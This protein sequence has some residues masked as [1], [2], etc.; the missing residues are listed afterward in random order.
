MR[1]V[2]LV[3]DQRA[4]ALADTDDA[5]VLVTEDTEAKAL[6]WD[7]PGHVWRYDVVNGNELVNETYVGPTR[8]RR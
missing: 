8:R 6:A 4:N 7:G 2:W 5:N 1:Q 3:Y